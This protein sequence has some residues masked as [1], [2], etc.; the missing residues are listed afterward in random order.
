[1]GIL[2][3]I[4]SELLPYQQLGARMADFCIRRTDL[5]ARINAASNQLSQDQ[6]R[7]VV[8]GYVDNSMRDHS[9]SF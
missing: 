1:M 5:E 9:G 4:S 8:T 6:I 2:G 3:G 7:A